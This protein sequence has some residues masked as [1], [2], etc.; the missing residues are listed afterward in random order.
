M[1]RFSPKKRENL[2]IFFLNARRLL[3]FGMGQGFDRF[4][5]EINSPTWD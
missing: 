3:A 1:D 2:S 4:A 5:F